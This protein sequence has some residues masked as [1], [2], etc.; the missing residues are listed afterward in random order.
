MGAE[1]FYDWAG[2]LVWLTLPEVADA[3]A[4]SVRAAAAK[5]KGYA[6][7]IRAPASVR[8]I[9]P[10]FEPQPSALAELSRRIKT[11]F[12]PAGVLNPGRFFPSGPGF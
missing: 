12:D 7:L 2:G 5:S 10:S 8:A 9:V 6:T 1:W 3:G 11:A 4:S